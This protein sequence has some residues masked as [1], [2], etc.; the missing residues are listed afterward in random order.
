M[1]NKNAEE[2]GGFAL[3]SPAPRRR[4]R[5]AAFPAPPGT[6]PGM[7]PKRESVINP[8]LWIVAAVLIVLALLARAATSGLNKPPPP[9]YV[10]PHSYD[11]P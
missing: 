8:R 11:G 4:C 5:P 2:A 1:Q 9:M 3:T 6:M 7:E 10:P